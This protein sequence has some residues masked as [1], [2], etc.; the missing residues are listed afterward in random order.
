LGRSVNRIS[1]SVDRFA[2]QLILRQKVDF[3]ELTSDIPEIREQFVVCAAH[4]L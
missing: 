4:F 3:G 2:A 1:F